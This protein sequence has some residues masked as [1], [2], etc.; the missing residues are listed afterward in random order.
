M[1]CLID[2]HIP[3]LAKI[4]PRSMTFRYTIG[5]NWER[6]LPLQVTHVAYAELAQL[7]EET[8]SILEAAS[9]MTAEAVDHATAAR[10]EAERE[11]ARRCHL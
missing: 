6:L 5:K 3:E 11:Y 4:D 7:I 10:V 9:G 1:A 8:S 2:A